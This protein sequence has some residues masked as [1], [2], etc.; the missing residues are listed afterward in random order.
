MK[1]R[2]PETPTVGAWL[3]GELA[4]GDAVGVD[5]ETI[6]D[7]A[8][9]SMKRSLTEKGIVLTP[10]A[11]NPVDEV[12]GKGRPASVTPRIQ[13][14]PVA[15]AGASVASKLGELR[16]CMR[17]ESAAVLVVGALD[18]VAW[19]LNLRGIGA[20]AYNPV[21]KAFCLVTQTEA[22]LYTDSAALDTP[23]GREATVAASQFAT[24]KPAPHASPIEHLAAAGVQVRPYDSVEADLL[25]LTAGE[26]AAAAAAEAASGS[27]TPGAIAAG[28]AG[29]GK[30]WIDAN[31]T[32]MRLGNVADSCTRAVL[33][34]R[35]PIQLL[36][37]VKSEAEIEGFRQAHLRDAL[38]VCRAL[39]QVE[40]AVARHEAGEGSAVTEWTVSGIFRAQR[41]A[42]NGFQ[43]LSFGT[44]AGS[45]ANGA[46]IHYSPKED[47]S[48]PVGSDRMLLVDSGGQYVD[49]T[50]DI[51]RTVHM[52]TPT[53][54]Q[55]RCFTRVLQGHIGLATVVF[56]EGTAG[57]LLDSFAR[58]ALWEDGLDYRHGTGHGVGS[59]LNVHEGPHGVSPRAGSL[60][61]G[62]REH[63]TV[64]DEPGYYEE[65]DGA[66]GFGIRIEDILVAQRAATPHT[67]GDKPYLRFES[68]NVVPITPKLVDTSV[69][70]AAEVAWLNAYN[71]RVRSRL[72]PLL[73]A[74]ISALE[75]GGPP[76]SA[77]AA[78]AGLITPETERATLEWVLRETESI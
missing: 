78:P 52:G 69:M 36:K 24:G 48:A 59:F 18:E 54:H 39:C 47:T 1:D 11:S 56:P 17:D 71:A 70:T 31:S 35:S 16:R 13:V 21:F 67:F 44:I 68:F 5:P 63:M 4:S 74:S 7:A 12:W 62:I 66:A 41:G 72:Q 45:G 25:A 26:E 53:A 3:A 49:G 28:R 37:A 30:V 38:A 46:I 23:E 61:V 10:V 42:L 20:I 58:R 29:S 32:N 76:H 51:T 50:T 22:F 34:K 55:S 43:D 73:E 15:L 57:T 64:T 6:S 27:S 8:A 9:A 60:G 14:Q 77:S 19:L 2:L 33:R 40:S 75:A 65:G